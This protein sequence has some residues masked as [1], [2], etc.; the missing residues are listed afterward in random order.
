VSLAG[1]GNAITR[2]VQNAAAYRGATPDK[3]AVKSYDANPIA[4]H[5]S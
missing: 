4:L 2:P 1:L 3:K 5:L